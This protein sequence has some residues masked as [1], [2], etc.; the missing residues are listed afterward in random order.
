M[1]QEKSIHSVIEK[2]SINDFKKN[3]D[4]LMATHFS[5]QETEELQ[6]R[7]DNT[8][9][10]FLAVKK[11]L[12]SL[13]K[14]INSTDSISEISFQLSHESSG[15]P[16]ITSLPAFCANGKEYTKKDFHISITH[17][18]SNAFGIAV[19]QENHND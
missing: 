14:S 6:S 1:T 16:C 9:A 7:P 4:E 8:R 13:C 18:R 12:S 11:A 5:L 10:G 17:N 2:V 15:A 19:F 3:K